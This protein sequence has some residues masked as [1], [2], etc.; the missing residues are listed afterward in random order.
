MIQLYL[1]IT[2]IYYLNTYFKPPTPQNNELMS[3]PR[4][5]SHLP[6]MCFPQET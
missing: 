5:F 6:L 1:S 2:N 3:C 4:R